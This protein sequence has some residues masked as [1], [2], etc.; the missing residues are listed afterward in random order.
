M[1]DHRRAAQ[2]IERF[3]AQETMRIGDDADQHDTSLSARFRQRLQSLGQL[4]E[5]PVSS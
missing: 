5:L 4:V 3:R 1:D 2:R